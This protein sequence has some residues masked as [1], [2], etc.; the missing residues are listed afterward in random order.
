M[1]S[2]GVLLGCVRRMVFFL[3]A[4]VFEAKFEGLNCVG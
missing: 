2:S 4:G 1:V 3:G